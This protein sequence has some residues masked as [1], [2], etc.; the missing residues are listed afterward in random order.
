MKH[1]IYKI[2][3]INN[4]KMYVGYTRR[5]IEQRFQEHLE[6]AG[7]FN[8]PLYNAIKKDG[9]DR[10]RIELIEYCTKRNVSNRERYWIKTLNTKN[11]NGYNLTKGGELSIAH[12]KRIR[13]RM[14]KSHRGKK[15]SLQTKQKLSISLTKSKYVISLKKRV[16][17]FTRGGKLVTIHESIIS[18]ARTFNKIN[19]NGEN[20]GS[21]A[22]VGCAKGR[23]K[24]AYGF[25]WRYENDDF[26]KFDTN[27]TKMYS[28]IQM[29]DFDGNL[30]KVFNGV[31]DA[32]TSC[33]ITNI[34]AACKGRATQAGGFVWRYVED[35]FDQF[36]QKHFRA[37]QNSSGE[38]YKTVLAA[39]NDYANIRN[40]KLNNA[41]TAISAC[42][43][44]SKKT[45]F[46]MYWSYA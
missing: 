13:K 46:G 42:L 17:Q 26:D 14:S 23:I 21:G 37:V 22:I 45:A 7:K 28:K 3:N 15:H 19:C 38:T 34:V 30:L 32:T 25:V 8:R 35:L 24:F 43:N 41:Q 33:K 11:P 39:A 2:V 18:A 31:S 29:F 4:G 6:S 5:T 27:S 9:K 20:E 36:N 12:L 10:F 40:I 44:G 1:K 16:K